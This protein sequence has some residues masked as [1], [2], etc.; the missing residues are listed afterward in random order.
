MPA[1]PIRAAL[2]AVPHLRA[3]PEDLLARIGGMARLRTL[4]AGTSIFR[5][6]DPARAFFVVRRGSVRVYRIAPGGAE[7]LVHHLRA[8]TSFGEPALFGTG[9]FHAFA[10]AGAEPTE[11]VEIDGA[12]FLALFR[13]DARL[14]SALVSALSARL[15]ELVGRVEELSLV[16]A[17]ARLARFLMRQPTQSQGQELR[18][19]LPMKKKD[20]ALQLAITP[21]TLSR[22]LRRWQDAG[23]IRSGRDEVRVLAAEALLRVADG[24]PAE[25]RSPDAS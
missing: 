7:Q 10:S 17:D 11:L 18:I 1:D 15:V 3:L 2:L 4:S 24:S 13:T 12:R 9:I 23:W 25:G 14:S 20:L 21:E 22:V 19:A 6:G 8:G 16:G 5:P